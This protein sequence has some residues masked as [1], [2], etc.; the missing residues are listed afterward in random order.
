M[1]YNDSQKKLISAWSQRTNKGLFKNAKPEQNTY[2]TT[3]YIPPETLNKNNNNNENYVTNN[4]NLYKGLNNFILSSQ[5][6]S[7]QL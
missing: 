5:Q 2:N 7:C 3:N 1:V 4:G 6:A